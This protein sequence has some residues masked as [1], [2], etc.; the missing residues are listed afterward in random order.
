MI[1]LLAL[2]LAGLPLYV[3]RFS[4]AGIPSTALELLI[5]LVTLIGAVQI[6][7]NSEVRQRLWRRRTWLLPAILLFVGATIGVFVSPDMRTALGLWKGFILDPILVLVLM[8]AFCNTED[9]LQR[10]GYGLV[11]GSAF[12]ACWAVIQAQLFGELRALGPYAL[13][14]KSSAN[15]L[16][17][18]LAPVVPLTLWLTH[19]L[20]PRVRAFGWILIVLL[21]WALWLSGSRAGLVVSLTGAILTLVLVSFRAGWV[22]RL[23]VV[24]LLLGAF[25]SWW[26]VQPNFALDAAN[27]GRITSSNNVRWQLWSATAELVERSPLL[28]IGLGNFQRAFTEQTAG[29]VNYPEFIAPVART[30]HN[31]LV[32]LWLEATI[33]GFIAGVAAIILALRSLF[34]ALAARPTSWLTAA[35]LGSWFYLMTHGLVDQPIWK[36]DLMVLFWF[37]FIVALVAHERSGSVRATH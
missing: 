19:T 23:L 12:V 6:G 15:Y 8:I 10:L 37:L 1:W 27:G 31:L 30:P 34:N 18:A 3:V 21:I 5:W 25:C 16:A 4:V 2:I 17:F 22:R 29:R 33:L 35:G 7:T 11:A 20:Q 28:G 24:G 9:D 36:N 32:D 26:V 14:D 13:D